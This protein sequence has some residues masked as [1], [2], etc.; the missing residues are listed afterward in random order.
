[1]R[2]YPPHEMSAATRLAAIAAAAIALGALAALPVI[3][4]RHDVPLAGYPLAAV[5]ALLVFLLVRA[6]AGASNARA[7]AACLIA[8]AALRIAVLIALNGLEGVETG[9]DYAAYLM[10]G[11]NLAEGEGLLAQTHYYGWVRGLYPPLYPLLLAGAGAVGGFNAAT[12]L[13]LNLVIDLA[14]AWLIF[15]LGRRLGDGRAGLAA[16]ALYLVWPS[17]VLGAPLAQK[18]GLVTLLALAM[19]LLFHKWLEEGTSWRNAALLGLTTALMALTQPMLALFPASI[20]LVL[21]PGLG[22]RPLA[23]LALRAIPLAVLALTPWWIRNYLTFGAFVPLTTSLG[24]TMIAAADPALAL[25]PTNMAGD[26][27]GRSAAMARQAMGIVGADPIGF[28]ARRIPSMLRQFL[29]EDYDALRLT[30]FRPPMNWARSVM[31]AAQLA[32]AAAAALAAAG[33]AGR[34]RAR[35]DGFAAVLVLAS[36]VQIGLF[37]FFF[38]FGERHRHF[39]TPF[40]LLLAAGWAVAALRRRDQKLSPS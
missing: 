7:V 18:E 16:A 5:W 9:N 20:A 1:M 33:L 17:L 39:L 12:V 40:L 32:F 22:P 37:N 23:L 29:F 27:A 19:A 34:A 31:P 4:V 28:I 10:L 30:G 24:P 26:E 13:I 35:R 8:A 15:L 11:R 21:L 2:P 38:L 3:A 25:V 14:A 6:S 36:L